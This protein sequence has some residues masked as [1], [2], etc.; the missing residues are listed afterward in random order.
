MKL[1]IIYFIRI[2]RELEKYYNVDS[3]SFV[4][5]DGKNAGQTV[6]HVH[7]HIIPRRKGDFERNDEIYDELERVD[8]ESRPARSV[9]I[10]KFKLLINF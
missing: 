1:I 2:G 4:I 3:L 7:V 9:C 8:A 5:Q 6:E 10:L